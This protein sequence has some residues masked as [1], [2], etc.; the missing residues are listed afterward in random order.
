M[1]YTLSI[2]SLIL[3]LSCKTSKETTFDVAT[4]EPILVVELHSGN[5]GRFEAKEQK[6]ITTKE[7][8]T[9]VWTK[10]YGN[11]LK[12]DPVPEVDFS[13]NVVL[14]VAMGEKNAGGYTIKINKVVGSK[15]NTVVSILET[16]PGK[17][18]NLTTAMTYPFQIVQIEKQAK[19]IVFNTTTKIIECDSE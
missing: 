12:K 3:L 13:K 4:N 5:N 9:D 17:N 1:K 11:Y 6:V 19:E 16:N 15:L 8:L 14:L 10:A 18:C 2:L 7:G